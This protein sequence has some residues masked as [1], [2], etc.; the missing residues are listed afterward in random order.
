MGM[1][2]A[3]LQPLSELFCQLDCSGIR[4][5]AAWFLGYHL[6]SDNRSCGHSRFHPFGRCWRVCE[7]SHIADTKRRFGHRLYHKQEREQQ[8]PTKWPSNARA[9]NDRL[10]SNHQTTRTVGLYSR[11]SNF[12]RCISHLLI[13][14]SKICLIRRA[15]DKCE[16]LKRFSVCTRE[17]CTRCTW[18]NWVVNLS[19][20]VSIRDL[21]DPFVGLT[22]GASCPQ[23]HRSEARP[24]HNSQLF[25]WRGRQL[26][27]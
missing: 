13:L 6:H 5:Q 2:F 1:A 11:S 25:W 21:G 7:G 4:R 18:W 16:D 23:V 15:I 10:R 26:R 22:H 3:F 24:T 19:D 27:S 17:S 8:Q 12:G 9:F 14:L 20:G